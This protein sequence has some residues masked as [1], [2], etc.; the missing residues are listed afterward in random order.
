MAL[1]MSVRDRVTVHNSLRE[2]FFHPRDH[3]KNSKAKE[4]EMSLCSGGPGLGGVRP[5]GIPRGWSEEL[6]SI[7]AGTEAW[8]V[9][10]RGKAGLRERD[11]RGQRGLQCA[12]RGQTDVGK[13]EARTR[14]KGSE[15]GLRQSCGTAPLSSPLQ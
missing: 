2:E 6:R 8:T 11:G 5:A 10:G 1:T 13:V 14:G 12:V 3:K 15:E 7:L 4:Q 9:P